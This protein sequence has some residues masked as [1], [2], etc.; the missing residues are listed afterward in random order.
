MDMNVAL[1]LS[2]RSGSGSG[3]GSGSASGTA[4]LQ[5]EF[6]QVCCE[7]RVLSQD[8]YDM[9]ENRIILKSS[10]S[11]VEYPTVG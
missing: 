11:T 5:E 7:V 6:K 1:A 4:K 3:S 8:F 9:P 2:C 10:Y